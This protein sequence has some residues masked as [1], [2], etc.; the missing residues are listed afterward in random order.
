MPLQL[1]IKIY[2]KIVVSLNRFHII[3]SKRI[4][5]CCCT[6]FIPLEC[7]I[8][9]H[10]WYNNFFLL[11]FI[12]KFHVFF[13]RCYDLHSQLCC[14]CV[15]HFL[16][17]QKNIKDECFCGKIRLDLTTEFKRCFYVA[18]FFLF[19]DESVLVLLFS[20]FVVPLETC[21]VHWTWYE[22]LLFT[23]DIT[24]TLKKK[25]KLQYNN[26]VNMKSK[27]RS[28]QTTTRDFIANKSFSK[29]HHYCGCVREKNCPSKRSSNKKSKRKKNYW[30]NKHNPTHQFTIFF[31]FFNYWEKQLF[32]SNNF[33]EFCL[34]A[35]GKRCLLAKGREGL[36]I[37]NL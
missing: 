17:F 9:C 3:L 4:N 32:I 18:L 37:S 29:S 25:A 8:L 2:W 1:P 22:C 28:T 30:T 7:Y 19:L 35:V 31:F 15:V 21:L 33:P 16:I 20:K 12:N 26:E 13:L 5:F 6:G 14:D 34:V 23:D 11:T 36:K 24:M 10:N 27:N